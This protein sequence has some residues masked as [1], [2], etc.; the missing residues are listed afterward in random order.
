MKDEKRD[1]QTGC[2]ACGGSAASAGERAGGSES[3]ARASDCASADEGIRAREM[4]RDG[5]GEQKRASAGDD[6]FA[7]LSETPTSNRTQ[8]AFF[9]VRNAGKSSLVNAILNQDLSVVSNVA[10]TT[11]DIV[12]K[13]MELKSA[14]PVSIID[15]PGI[16]DVGALGTKRAQ[17]A[18][19]VLHTCDVAVLVVS[20]PDGLSRPDIDLISLFCE[21]GVPF[22]V[23]A[24]KCDLV[25]SDRISVD[26]SDD[27]LDGG[28]L[29]SDCF[30]VSSID[31]PILFCSAKNNSGIDSLK[32][33]MA[34]VCVKVQSD[35]DKSQVCVRDLL[36]VGDMVVLVIPIDSAAP[37]DRIILPQQIVMRDVL[38]AHASFV[39]CQVEELDNVL[40]KF[41]AKNTDSCGCASDTAST[42]NSA[43]STSAPN[44]PN[45]KKSA[46]CVRLVITDSQAF[47]QV[48][49]IVPESVPLTSFSILMARYKGNIDQLVAGARTLDLLTDN[50]SVLIAEGCSHHRTCED[51][52]SVK[53]PALIK[54][55]CS[56]TP[57]FTFTSGRGFPK[58]L[59]S[60][61]LI[62]HCGGCML[63]EKEMKYRLSCA[64]NQDV[65]VVNYGV[66]ISHMLGILSR[67]IAPLGL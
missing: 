45:S 9:G 55:H 58:D 13:A 1:I 26:V 7:T 53:I 63:N 17:R 27:C 21:S 4:A 56:A 29:G 50:S 14:G 6:V 47:S 19:Q 52:G 41:G 35:R 3:S 40:N 48:A 42:A 44:S 57:K 8:I 66:A 2:G 62:I 61:D 23:A 34:R 36:E 39:A 33:E 54:K 24:N 18:R 60:F 37:R 15:T 16:D 20:A 67:V 25:S 28:C 32:H 30:D 65:P 11:T 38:D 10:G 59:S 51:I 12:R 22:I 49:Q 31:A 46:P 64:G 43:N 5:K